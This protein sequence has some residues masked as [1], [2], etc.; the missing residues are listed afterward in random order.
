MKLRPLIEPGTLPV[1]Q[2]TV[3][4]LAVFKRRGYLRLHDNGVLTV[5]LPG[6]PP[7][8]ARTPAHGKG[9]DRRMGVRTAEQRAQR[10][11]TQLKNKGFPQ[12]EPETSPGVENPLR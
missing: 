2:Y 9:G 4:E 8:E 10:A 11:A 5:H 7:V 1:K 3:D 12:N 6:A